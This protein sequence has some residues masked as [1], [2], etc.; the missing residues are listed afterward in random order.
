MAFVV[1]DGT[2]LSTATSYVTVEEA[3]EY[4][5]DRGNE[6]W[7]A[8]T[9]ANKEIYLIKATDFIDANYTFVGTR[10]SATQALEW[11]R[12]DAT[13][14]NNNDIEDDEIPIVLKKA[15]YEAAMR[16][17][18]SDDGLM[19]DYEAGTGAVKVREIDGIREEFYNYGNTR[20]SSTYS[21][22]NRVIKPILT[23][24]YGVSI[25]ATR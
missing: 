17:P 12:E 3:D 11:P 4:F 8:Y 10:G 2:G 9:D 5:T 7:L 23:T 24:T 13:D 1:E 6:T 21:Y 25:S 16:V 20:V 15:V 14:S 22:I 18:L 19:P